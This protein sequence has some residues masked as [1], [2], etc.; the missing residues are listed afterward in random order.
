MKSVVCFTLALGMS[1]AACAIPTLTGPT[2]GFTEQHAAVASGI[3]V[4]ID[5]STP[6]TPGMLGA[7]NTRVLFGDGRNYEIGGAFQQTITKDRAWNVN[8]KYLLPIASRNVT[9]AVSGLYGAPTKAEHEWDAKLIASAMISND[10]AVSA[11]VGYINLLAADDNSLY[12]SLAASKYVNPQTVIGGELIFGNELAPYFTMADALQQT[13]SPVPPFVHNANRM[14][15]NIYSSYNLAENTV[16]RAGL[17]G[18]GQGTML[19]LGV[20]YQIGQ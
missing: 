1:L 9:F 14:H 4:A 16:A 2:G 3:Q 13:T 17:I 7:P 5:Q 15:M 19:F 20:S 18:I 10:I 11:N 12:A 6:A 8:A